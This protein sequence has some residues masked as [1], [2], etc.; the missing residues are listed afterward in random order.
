MPQ[1]KILYFIIVS[2]HHKAISDHEND[3]E[4]D[5]EYNVVSSTKKRKSMYVYTF[6]IHIYFFQNLFFKFKAV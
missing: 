1:L 3:S 4:T 2:V 5:N 6:V